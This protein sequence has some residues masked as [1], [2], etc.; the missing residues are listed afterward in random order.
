MAYVDIA[1]LMSIVPGEPLPAAVM[2]QIRDNQ[3]FLID[4]PACSVFNSTA[5][6]V[7]HDTPSVLAANSELFDND[8]M[9]STSVSN[10][11]ITIQTPGRYQLMSVIEFAADADG[12]RAAWFRVDGS[13]NVWGMRV[14]TG[15]S[16]VTRLV[17]IRQVVLTAGQYVEA[18]V[19]HT[20]GNALDV[21][22]LEFAALFLTR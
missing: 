13:T 11:R 3:E 2:Q 21:S 15:T 1:T 4:P 22:L 17:T 14:G 7:S 10:S 19:S 5:Q 16:T 6:S 18:M 20:A 9:H 12:Y 8:S